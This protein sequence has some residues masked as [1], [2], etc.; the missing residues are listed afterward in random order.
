[1]RNAIIKAAGGQVRVEFEAHAVAHQQAFATSNGILPCKKI[2]FLPWR[3]DQSNLAQLQPSL[4]RF[5]SSAVEYITAN[6]HQ[7]LG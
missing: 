4:E 6:G 7:T 5:V 2:L 3:V 1:M